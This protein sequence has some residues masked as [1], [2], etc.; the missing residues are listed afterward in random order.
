MS[1]NASVCR[2]RLSTVSRCRPRCPFSS[3]HLRC[4][5][6]PAL[7]TLDAMAVRLLPQY[8]ADEGALTAVQVRQIK[9]RVPQGKKHSLR[10]S[11]FEVASA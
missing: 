5:H 10:S 9:K 2:H 4:D 1:D 7:D 3:K 8:A 11:L 6:A